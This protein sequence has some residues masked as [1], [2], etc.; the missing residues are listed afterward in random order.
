V[1]QPGAGTAHA[2][3]I[4]ERQPGR[5][6]VGVLVQDHYAVVRLAAVACGREGADHCRHEWNAQHPDDPVTEAE[7]QAWTEKTLAAMRSAR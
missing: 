4:T 6:V 1:G 3:V 5:D 2:T 7:Q